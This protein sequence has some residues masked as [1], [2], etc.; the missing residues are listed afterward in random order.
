M[1]VDRRYPEV[2][3]V[4]CGD[5]AVTVV[6]GAAAVSTEVGDVTVGV[7]SDGSNGTSKAL[8]SSGTASGETRGIS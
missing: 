2:G 1:R 3:D 8:L 6:V 7:S 5:L 4:G